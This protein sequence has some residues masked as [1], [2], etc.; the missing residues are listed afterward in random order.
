[1]RFQVLKDQTIIISGT[2]ADLASLVAGIELARSEPNV[3]CES[4]ILTPD[5]VI[6]IILR[7][8]A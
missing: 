7:C 3:D 6:P 5:G 4:S 2:D 1:M 8:D